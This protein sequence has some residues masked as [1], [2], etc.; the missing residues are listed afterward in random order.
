VKAD[1]DEEAA[2]ESLKLAEAG[3]WS[4]RKEAVSVTSSAGEA[5]SADVEAAA[6][7]P[8]DRAQSIGEGGC[9]EQQVFSEDESA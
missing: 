7:Y 3:S 8:E 1:R 4:L 2:G 5:A 6:G 9:T